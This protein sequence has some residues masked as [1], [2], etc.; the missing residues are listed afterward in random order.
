MADP[1]SW[2]SAAAIRSHQ[3]REGPDAAEVAAA[4]VG[5]ANIDHNPT[6][7]MGGEDFSYMLNQRPGSYVWIGNGEAK[8]EEMLL[9]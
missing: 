7:S 2:I 9:T 1:E 5:E 6:P 8:P 4:L 3:Q